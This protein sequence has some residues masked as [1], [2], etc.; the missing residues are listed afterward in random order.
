MT[1]NNWTP[2]AATSWRP[3]ELLKPVVD[4]AGWYPADFTGKDHWIYRLSEAEIAEIEDAVDLNEA[5][6]RQLAEIGPAEFP[7]PRLGKAMKDLQHEV[8][9]GRGFVLVRGLPIE[10]RSRFQTALAFWGLGAHMGKAVA[11]N[12]KGHLLG[13]VK[14]LG[15]DYEKVRGYMTKASMGFHTDRAD[16]LSLCCLH[17]AKSGGAH[18]IASSI[19]IYNEL[20][21]RRPEL[22]KELTFPFYKS[23]NGEIPPGVTTPWI[24]L[25]TYT[26]KDGYL[27]V[28]GT[29]RSV[30][31][32]QE[33]PG[34]P[35]LTEAQ[36][37]AIKMLKD[38]AEEVYLDIDFE[39]GDISYVQN[40][41]T[42]HAR[43]AFEDFPEPERKRHLYRL[44]LVN[45][46]RPVTDDVRRD[47]SGVLMKDLV[48]QTP[49]DVTA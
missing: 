23:L 20:L 27:S 29:N 3:A 47:V 6:G 7:L 19:T 39:L 44:W 37:E 34:V 46:L 43:S 14:D 28:R 22:V 5:K 4:P 25:P 30:R 15:G 48:L 11:Q 16:I 32:A 35:K 26:I 10:G 31:K 45:G 41:V 8:M 36:K 17:P 42:V 1:K 21:K 12:A 18:R 13:H 2:S 38:L 40:L 33:M 49:L 9:R 24:R